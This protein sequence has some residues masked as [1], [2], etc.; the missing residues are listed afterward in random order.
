MMSAF[1]GKFPKY[2]G[3]LSLFPGIFHLLNWMQSIKASTIVACRLYPE[4]EDRMNANQ[5]NTG[6]GYW[7]AWFLASTIGFGMGAIFISFLI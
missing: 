5:V 4:R 3:S 7:L 2:S 1:S 6:R